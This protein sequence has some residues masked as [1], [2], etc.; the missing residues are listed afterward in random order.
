MHHQNG[1]LHAQNKGKGRTH[2]GSLSRQAVA[3]HW[4]MVDPSCPLKPSSRRVRTW[5]TS[6]LDRGR[7]SWL[8]VAVAAAAAAAVAAGAAAGISAAAGA[9]GR[10]VVCR[11][12]EAGGSLMRQLA[13]SQQVE[14]NEDFPPG[15]AV[16]APCAASARCNAVRLLDRASKGR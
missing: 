2:I 4:S 1:V 7:P 8:A 14:L 5:C 13:W 3:V 15:K 16:V 11:T 9:T 12:P 10:C 6:T